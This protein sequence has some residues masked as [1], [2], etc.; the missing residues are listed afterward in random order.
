MP[1][2]IKPS[3]DRVVVEAAAAE[4]NHSLSCMSR[5]WS[6]PYCELMDIQGEKNWIGKFMVDGTMS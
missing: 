3:G 5:L 1:L 6:S 4:R 2:N